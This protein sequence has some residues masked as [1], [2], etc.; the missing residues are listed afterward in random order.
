M[1]TSE[2][3]SFINHCQRNQCFC[4]L[5]QWGNRERAALYHSRP[6]VGFCHWLSHTPHS[7]H[8]SVSTMDRSPSAGLSAGLSLKGQLP[9][10]TQS[11]IPPGTLTQRWT[12]IPPTEKIH[13]TQEQS[14]ARFHR[15]SSTNIM[16][17][18]DPLAQTLAG[19]AILCCVQALKM[20]SQTEGQTEK[21]IWQHSVVQP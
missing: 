5:L 13:T 12:Q 7:H 11:R 8:V 18:N 20:S 10:D 21:Q 14:R 6:P 9:H 15:F 3:K 17:M 4:E 2:K 1:I 16:N 19:C